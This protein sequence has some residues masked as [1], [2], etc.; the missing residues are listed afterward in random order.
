MK[1][2]HSTY[3]NPELHVKIEKPFG[4]FFFCDKFILSEIYEGIHF[5][6]PMISCLLDDVVSFY[7]SYANI[8]YISNRIYSYSR[9]PH[10]WTEIDKYNII[11]ASA[12]V[13][14]NQMSY[15]NATLEKRFSKKSIKRCDTLDQA[16]E[17]IINLKEL[18]N[19]SV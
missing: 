19:V 2:E 9:D 16:I 8:G 14:Y 1:F 5:D 13:S 4:R 10:S 3:Y 17:W 12:I 7:G 11:V 6:W 18:K 15:L